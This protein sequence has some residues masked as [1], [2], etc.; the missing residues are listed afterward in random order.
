LSL[1]ILSKHGQTEACSFD[2]FLAALDDPVPALAMAPEVQR[3]RTKS[4][5]LAGNFASSA[6]MAPAESPFWI[7]VVRSMRARQ[8]RIGVACLLVAMTLFIMIAGRLAW[9][10]AAGAL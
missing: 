2:Q 8:D 3:Q 7:G 5:H 9:A 10:Y 4:R 6:M 1:R